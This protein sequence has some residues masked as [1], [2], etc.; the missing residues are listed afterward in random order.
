MGLMV[1]AALW[2]FAEATLF[3]I[4]PDVL[5][6]GVA[7]RRDRS[8]AL[9]ATAWTI[10]GAVAG[11][12]LM[13]G[14]GMRDAAGAAAMLD[15][16]PAIAP[17]MIARVGADLQRAGL[18]AMAIGAFSGVPYKIYAVMAPGAGIG[19]G[20]FLAASVPIRALRFVVVVFIADGLN[21]LLARRLSARRRIALLLAFWVVFYGGYFALMPN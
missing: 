11:G 3:V 8:T 14:W 5:L 6:T 9:A 15:R 16:L 19:L 1:L 4:V 2:G 13:Y 17:A 21:R 10:A 12:V 18:P 20:A 7:V